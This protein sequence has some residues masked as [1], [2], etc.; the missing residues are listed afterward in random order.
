MGGVDVLD[1][2]IEYYRTFMKTKK[3]TLKFI[4][5]FFDLAVAN[6]WRMYKIHSDLA[7]TH[8]GQVMDLLDFKLQVA[9]GLINTPNRPRLISDENEEDV[10]N[11][12]PNHPSRRYRPANP[13]SE[14]KRYDGYE[15]YPEFDEIAS[16]RSCRMEGCSSRSK[17]R[18][19]KCNV[20]LCLTRKSNC[21]ASYHKR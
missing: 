16:P 4:L 12:E 17:I 19:C 7:H 1:Q 10:E 13:P 5:H 14:P 15:H 21:F 8:R 11:E 3:W 6:A 2:S 9:D 20:Y 18:C